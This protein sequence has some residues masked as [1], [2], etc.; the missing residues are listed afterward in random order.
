MTERN[1]IKRGTFAAP[2]PDEIE[3]AAANVVH[4]TVVHSAMSAFTRSVGGDVCRTFF[5]GPSRRKKSF[6]VAI[7]SCLQGREKN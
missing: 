4:Q 5:L 7:F 2:W 6:A 3:V 1:W